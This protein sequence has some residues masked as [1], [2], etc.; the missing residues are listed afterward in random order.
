MH[1]RP[2]FEAPAARLGGYLEHLTYSDWDQYLKKQFRYAALW[3]GEKHAAGRKSGPWRAVSRGFL[4]FFKMFFL[5]LGILG[6][7]ETWA[8]CAY[9]SLYTMTKYLKLAELNKHSAYG[10]KP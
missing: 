3:A 6:G 2:V 4:G 5:N 8:L 10:P 9:H 1:E 7:P